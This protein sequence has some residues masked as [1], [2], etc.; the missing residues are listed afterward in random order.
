MNSCNFI[1]RWMLSPKITTFFS[2]SKLFSETKD[3]FL[4][5]FFS[6]WLFSATDGPGDSLKVLFL[7]LFL[8]EVVSSALTRYHSI[9]CR[10]VRQVHLSHAQDLSWMKYP[11]N[12]T[13]T[14]LHL[15]RFFFNLHGIA[16]HILTENLLI[17]EILLQVMKLV[18]F[19]EKI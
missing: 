2:F 13:V 16:E 8:V 9:W 6:V 18:Q 19:R 7:V 10:Q 17:I 3:F 12:S 14:E 11:G 4:S 15:E 1:P 5:K